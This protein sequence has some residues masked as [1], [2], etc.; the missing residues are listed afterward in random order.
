MLNLNKY[1]DFF[2]SSVKVN[3]MYEDSYNEM[4]QEAKDSIKKICEGLLCKEGEDYQNDED[5]SHTYERYADACS[6]DIKECM[7][8]SG[9]APIAKSNAY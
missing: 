5:N 4:S 2:K 9:Y 1:E 6:R 8:R 7:G 3:E